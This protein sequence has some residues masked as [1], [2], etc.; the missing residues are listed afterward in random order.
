[1]QANTPSAHGGS[2]PGSGRPPRV[3]GPTVPIYVRVPAHVAD[4]LDTLATTGQT[5]R[6]EAAR[7][8][9]TDAAITVEDT[10]IQP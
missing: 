7:R 5:T 1:M 2:R 9:L 3:A 4:W 10:E 6:T 8:I